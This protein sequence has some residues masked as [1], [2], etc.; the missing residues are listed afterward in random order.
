MLYFGQLV[1][2]L[3]VFINAVDVVEIWLS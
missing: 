1:C 2:E 3:Y